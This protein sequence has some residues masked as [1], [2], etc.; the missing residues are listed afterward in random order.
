MLYLVDEMFKQRN[1]PI[2]LVFGK[3]ISYTSFDHT[4]S[5]SEWAGVVREKAYAL[6]A[7]VNG[8]NKNWIL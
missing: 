3:P 5:A 7:V 8:E 1:K 6:R 2:T 4:K